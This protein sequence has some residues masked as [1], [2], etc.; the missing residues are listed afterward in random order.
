MSEKELQ[1][2]KERL[3]LFPENMN[4]PAQ[5]GY[6]KLFDY[7]N[8][9]QSQLQEYVDNY[10]EIDNRILKPFATILN[11]YYVYKEDNQVNIKDEFLDTL[12]DLI[13]DG[14]VEKVGDSNE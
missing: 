5:E 2:I 13:L 14:L 1:D 3:D 7:I 6:Y 8:N 12:Y 10:I 9:L 4:K 11:G